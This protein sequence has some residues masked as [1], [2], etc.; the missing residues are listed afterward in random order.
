MSEQAPKETIYKNTEGLY[1]KD[2]AGTIPVESSIDE[3]KYDVKSV[4]PPT[5]ESTPQPPVEGGG[6]R[7]RA[8]KTKKSKKAKKTKKTR[9][10]RKG[11][12]RK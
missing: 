9:K 7:K 1:F 10:S 11:K 8:K 3:S 5:P 6:R 4:V 12:A 2:E